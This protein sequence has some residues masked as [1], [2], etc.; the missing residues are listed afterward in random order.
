MVASMGG[1]SELEIPYRRQGSSIA[2][3]F[4]GA[5]SRQN[6]SSGSR[7]WGT[8][9]VCDYPGCETKLSIYNYDVCCWTHRGFKRYR[10]RGRV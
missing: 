4:A 3:V 1:P 2:P 7:V 9:R 10:L 6:A 5:P 8:G